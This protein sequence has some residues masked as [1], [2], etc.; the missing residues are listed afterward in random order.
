MEGTTPTETVNAYLASFYSGDYDRAVSTLAEDFSFQGPFLRV[1]GRAAF[2]D[3]AQG[4]RPVVRGHRLLYQWQDGAE[5]CSIYEVELCTPA[6]S[7][8]VLMSE[9]H[10]VCD[11]RLTRGRVV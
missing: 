6:G 2:L 7:G 10:T 4:L 9:W 8:S 11:G 3:G 1:E 5:V